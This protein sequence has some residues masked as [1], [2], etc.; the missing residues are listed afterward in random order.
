MTI[1]TQT[2]D[3]GLTSLFSGERVS[4]DDI[5][6][7]AC[8]T[9]DELYAFVSEASLSVARVENIEILEHLKPTLRR[10]MSELSSAQKSFSN[11]ISDADI[12]H[13]T[14][15]VKKY[16]KYLNITGFVD[17]KENI[18][19]A[20]LDICRAVC[21]RAERRIVSLSKVTEVSENLLIYI[22]RLSDLLFVMSRLE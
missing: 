15:L 16:E 1:M 6:I 21:R 4:K 3:R 18:P 9:M 20:K 10:V 14:L 13:L 19:S 5:R 2:G 11:P 12:D 7:E 22:N 8:G 17:A